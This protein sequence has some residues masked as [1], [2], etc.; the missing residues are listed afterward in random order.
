M[1]LNK[2]FF[3]LKHEKCS[4]VPKLIKSLLVSCCITRMYVQCSMF[5]LQGAPGLTSMMK[6]MRGLYDDLESVMAPK[7]KQPLFE[8]ILEHLR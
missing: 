6:E 2:M 1:F 8:E 4:I 7:R 5:N 3:F